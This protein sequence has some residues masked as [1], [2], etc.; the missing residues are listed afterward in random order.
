MMLDTHTW[1]QVSVLA[2]RAV[3]TSLAL[4]HSRCRNSSKA[5]AAAAGNFFEV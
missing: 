4:V 3:A 1:L 2:F 5:R